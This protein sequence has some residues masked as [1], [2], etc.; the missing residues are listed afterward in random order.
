MFNSVLRAAVL[1]LGLAVVAAPSAFADGDAAAGK[2]VFRKCQACH[3]LEEGKN[4]VGPTLYGLI[5]RKAGSLDGFRFSKG[6]TA[7]DVVWS[8]ETLD[9]YLEDPRGL[10]KGTRMAFPGLKKA[11]DRADVIAYILANQ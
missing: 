10:V 5:G 8:A 9:T 3:T 4:R 1:G 6:M 2:K 11:Q 7:Y